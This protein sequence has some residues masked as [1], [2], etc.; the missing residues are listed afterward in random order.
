MKNAFFGV[1]EAPF[2]G[3]IVGRD[4]L[5]KLHPKKIEAN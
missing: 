5:N 1:S 3:H 4:G 2:L